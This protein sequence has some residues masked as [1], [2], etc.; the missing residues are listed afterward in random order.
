MDFEAVQVL[1]VYI[2]FIEAEVNQTCV[3]SYK[4]ILDLQKAYFPSPTFQE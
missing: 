4:G 2:V 3:L 1:F